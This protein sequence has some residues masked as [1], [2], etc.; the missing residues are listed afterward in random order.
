[1][2][3]T[4]RAA[5]GGRGCSHRSGGKRP[6]SRAADTLVPLVFILPPDLP[7]E[8]VHHYSDGLL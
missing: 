6:L 3:P 7:L 4:V 2:W 8:R 1:M 5:Q